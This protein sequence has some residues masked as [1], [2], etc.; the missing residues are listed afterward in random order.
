MGIRY[1]CW[2]MNTLDYYSFAGTATQGGKAPSIPSL[3]ISTAL[4]IR[5]K[6]PRLSDSNVSCLSLS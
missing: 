1:P 5:Q 6:G 2:A 4:E 3:F